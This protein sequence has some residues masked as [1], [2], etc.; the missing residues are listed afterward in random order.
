[1]INKLYSIVGTPA[2]LIGPY[3]PT[4]A[5]DLPLRLILHASVLFPFIQTN[6]VAISTSTLS[7]Q[8]VCRLHRDNSSTY[9]REYVSNN[10]T[11]M[12]TDILLSLISA[13]K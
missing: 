5:M 9:F 4:L 12:L 10:E 11:D 7:A 8:L 3:P 6:P 13:I 1:M 2:H